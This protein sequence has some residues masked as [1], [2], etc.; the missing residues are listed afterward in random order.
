[1]IVLN[2]IEIKLLPVILIEFIVSYCRKMKHSQRENLL[3]Q[4]INSQ[5][6]IRKHLG[7]GSFGDVYEAED[8]LTQKIVALKFENGNAPNP[9]LPNEYKYYNILQGGTNIPKVYGL[10]DYKKGRFL[11]MDKMGPSL[12]A[13]FRLCNHT[14]SLKTVL[15]L[16]DQM[17]RLI[18][19]V[20][21]C[22]IIHRDIKPQ[23]FVIG[24]NNLK[25]RIY[26][27][28]FGI[29]TQW[30][31]TRTGEQVMFTTNNGLVGTAYY[32][33]INV[34]LGDQQAPRDDLESIIYVLIRF[35]KGELP[36]QVFKYKNPEE[37]NRKISQLK[38]KIDSEALCTGLPKEF[39]ILLD[40][41]RRLRYDEPPKYS[42]MRHVV[43]KLIED[44]GYINDGIFDWDDEAS[45]H[46]PIPNDYLYKTAIAYLRRNERK[47]GN[48]K[49]KVTLPTPRNFF[50]YG[51]K[52]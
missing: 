29:S 48:K 21:H 28:D 36:W 19:Y 23:N 47:L 44:S 4:V 27:L 50:I 38:L 45:I 42:W 49:Q 12:E 16:A 31:D 7:S 17:F 41:V 11:V 39:T 30:I 46:P 40:Y 34:H 9:Q 25:R 26:L 5:Y 8:I 43:A 1:M 6:K 35:L 2:V 20:H 18:E 3:G 52:K 22:G 32:V 33:S 14:F 24:R 37:R 10:Y 13:L 15:M 51:S